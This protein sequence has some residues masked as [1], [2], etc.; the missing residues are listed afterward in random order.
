MVRCLME[1]FIDHNYVTN[2]A[3]MPHHQR[4]RERNDPVLI[5]IQN[6]AAKTGSANQTFCWSQNQL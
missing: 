5:N 4:L 2:G 6:T 1:H 3:L